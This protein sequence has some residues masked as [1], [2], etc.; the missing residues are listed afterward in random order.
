MDAVPRRARDLRPLLRIPLYMARL[1]FRVGNDGMLL[2]LFGILDDLRERHLAAAG[3]CGL[4]AGFAAEVTVSA[5]GK[6]LVRLG[7]EMARQAEFIVVLDVVVH[8]VTVVRTRTK[9]RE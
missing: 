4:V 9:D 6:A 2:E 3:E 7:H 5:L 8:T 1:A